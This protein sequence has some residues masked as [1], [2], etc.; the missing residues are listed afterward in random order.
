MGTEQDKSSKKKERAA[1]DSQS[2]KTKK[3][4]YKKP[5]LIK[6]GLLSIIEGD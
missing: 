1:S 2:S 4:P 6:Q 5:V 3:K